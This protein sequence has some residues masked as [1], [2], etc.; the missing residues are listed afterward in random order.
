[1]GIFIKGSL[2]TACVKATAL[3]FGKMAVNITVILNKGIGMGMGY[4]RTSTKTK[5]IR[6][7]ICWTRNMDMACIL[8]AMDTL[9]RAII[10]RMKGMDR[11]S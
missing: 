3:T 1:M 6:D 10:L 11:G 2:L 7:T 8:G 5:S 9:I 4:G